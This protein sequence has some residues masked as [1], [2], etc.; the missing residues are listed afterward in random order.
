[1]NERQSRLL[2]AIIDEFITTAVPVGSKQIVE[3]GYF[4]CSGATVRNEMQTLAEEGFIVQPHTSAGRIPTARGYRTYVRECIKPSK[5]EKQV[6]KRFAEL[7]TEYFKR[8]DQERVYDAVAMLSRMT[9]NV[10]FATVPHKERVYYLG[11]C[12]VLKQPEFLVDPRLASGIAEVLEEKFDTLLGSLEVDEQVRCYI[13]E[14]NLLEQVQSCSVMMTSFAVRADDGV[15]GILGPMRMDYA[16]NQVV[17]DV[18][19]DMLRSQ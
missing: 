11:L 14:E 1:M 17:L 8:K 13:G 18:V 7:K 16:Y 6:R 3:K 15:I 2:Q 12:N 10:V 9:P 19:A 5:C 4:D